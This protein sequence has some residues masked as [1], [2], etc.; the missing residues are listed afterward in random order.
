MSEASPTKLDKAT[1]LPII[2]GQTDAAT[3]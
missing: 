1:G 2:L 3:S